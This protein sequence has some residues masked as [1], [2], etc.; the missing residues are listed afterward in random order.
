MAATNSRI[1]LKMRLRQRMPVLVHQFTIDRNGITHTPTGWRRDSSGTITKG[2]DRD[3]DLD[4]VA[5]MG[6][7]RNV[8]ANY[9]FERSHKFPGISRIRA[10]ETIRV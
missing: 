9:L 2:T 6:H 4:Q 1:D 5:E 10:A 8:A 7:L 3:F